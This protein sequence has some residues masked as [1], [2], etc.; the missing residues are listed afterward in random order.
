MLRSQPDNDATALYD[1]ELVVEVLSPSN[2]RGEM[3]AKRAAYLTLP[4]LVA[5]LVV[6]GDTYEAWTRIGEDSPWQCETVNVGEFSVTL[7][8]REVRL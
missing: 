2:R 7:H 8:G 1:A 3:E 5:F 6:D 4:S